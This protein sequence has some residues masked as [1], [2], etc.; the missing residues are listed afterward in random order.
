[1]ETNLFYQQLEEGSTS[2]LKKY[3]NWLTERYEDTRWDFFQEKDANTK[4]WLRERAAKLRNA[5]LVLE[6][7]VM[8]LDNGLEV[9]D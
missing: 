2:E 6:D 8:D 4:D 3:Y 5:I 7:Y 1:M 9:L